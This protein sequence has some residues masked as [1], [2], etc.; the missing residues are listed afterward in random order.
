MEDATILILLAQYLLGVSDAKLYD[1]VSIN[2]AKYMSNYP[3]A[4]CDDFESDSAM[5]ISAGIID[6]FKSKS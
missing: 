4:T 5:S 6:Y 2:L 3:D 1:A